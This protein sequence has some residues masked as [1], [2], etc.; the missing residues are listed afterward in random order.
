MTFS[1]FVHVRGSTASEHC[2]LLQDKTM[3]DSDSAYAR[4]LLWGSEAPRLLQMLAASC[5]MND[6][7]VSDL[8]LAAPKTTTGL[9]TGDGDSYQLRLMLQALSIRTER[10]CM[11]RRTHVVP[12]ECALNNLRECI[13]VLLG[14][15]FWPLGSRHQEC[16]LPAARATWTQLLAMHCH[17][18]EGPFLWSHTAAAAS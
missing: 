3:E 1:Q 12:H 2:A 18:R 17:S 14:L 4:L 9:K 8:C 7:T 11:H 15:L 6:A 16:M 13:S 10:V 5:V